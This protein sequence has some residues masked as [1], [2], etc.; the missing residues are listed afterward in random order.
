[1]SADLDPRVRIRLEELSGAERATALLLAMGKPLADKIVKQF[2]A[3]EL[4]IVARSAAGLGSVE[5][6]VV[7]KIIDDLVESLQLGA[8]LVGTSAHA[9]QLIAGN[10]SDEE[11]VEILADVKGGSTKAVWP[12]LS[13]TPEINVAQFLAKE[14]PQVG[15]Y[16]LSKV[17]PEMAAA[18]VGQ[19]PAQMRNELM[20]RMLTIKPV[21]E[22]A[23]TIL[24]ETLATNLLSGVT[25]SSGPNLQARLADI[26]NKLDKSQMDE[27]LTSLED[28]RPKEAAVVKGLLFTF[29]D[30]VKLSP[31]ARSRLFDEASTEQTV[32]ALKGAATEIVDVALAAVSARAKRMIEQE[33]SGG[34]PALKKDILKAQRQ[35]AD[36]ALE[37]ADRGLIELNPTSE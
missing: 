28:Y 18:I 2:D 10:I 16:V 24:E 27:V 30:I 29:E 23:A 9:E 21:T 3:S 1:M 26:L 25:R 12:R 36:L 34:A 35:I 17:S 5:P 15:A 32:L 14:H 13:K 20:R 19:M 6:P 11:A 7:D 4:K 31:E 8:D 37:M 22:E 33:L